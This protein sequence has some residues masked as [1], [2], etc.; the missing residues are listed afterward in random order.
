[1][2]EQKRICSRRLHRLLILHSRWLPRLSPRLGSPGSDT[3]A[4][5]GSEGEAGRA[6]T[7]SCSGPG[8]FSL[9]FPLL[10]QQCSLY[11]LWICTQHILTRRLYSGQWPHSH[12]EDHTE[13]FKTMTC[14]LPS[15]TVYIVDSSTWTL[16]L[17][18][19]G[20]WLNSGWS[21]IRNSAIPSLPQILGLHKQRA[22]LAPPMPSSRSISRARCPLPQFPFSCPEP[23]SSACP[24]HLLHLLASLA[25]MPTAPSY[26]IISSKIPWSLTSLI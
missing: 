3:S 25:P 8:P 7:I 23:H 26:W 18:I 4:G 11:T 9:D 13:V 2:R 15:A 20:T 21:L 22:A 12:V 6:M 17:E 16:Y 19:H 14:H 1:M 5:G 24:L 10:V